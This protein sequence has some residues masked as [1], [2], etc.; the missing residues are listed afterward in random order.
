MSDWVEHPDLVE[1]YSGNRNHPDDLY[2]S[3]RRYLP[4]LSAGAATVLDVGCGA[5]GFAAIWRTFNPDIEY[6][7]VDA[8]EGLVDAARRLHPAHTFVRADGAGPL[9]FDDQS[10]DVVAALGWLHLDA[11]YPRALAELWRVTRRSLF[12]DVR[13]LDRPDDVVGEQRLAL[14][15]DWDGHTTIPYVCASW[16]A[17][18]RL[19]ARLGPGRLRAYGYA[20]RP[21]AT[22]S[23]V[24]DEVYL[25]TIVLDRGDGPLELELDLP[26]EWP[27]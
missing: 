10:F 24:P 16:P 8:S 25:T 26:L 5:G 12:F 9:P 20:G 15:G 7:G 11:R 23:G 27:A 6:T 22:V 17:L 1:F 13:L 21:A 14:A 4:D 19:L 18:A 2:P 3:E